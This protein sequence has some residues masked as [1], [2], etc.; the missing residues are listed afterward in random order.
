MHTSRLPNLES[1]TQ[2]AGLL[3]VVMNR[4]TPF[5]LHHYIFHERT[6]SN[7]GPPQSVYEYLPLLLRQ[8][9]SNTTLHKIV[10]A[11]GLAALANSV[12]SMP[13]KCEAYR[14][15]G[16][17]V[18]QLQVDLHDSVKMKSDS[19]LASIMMMSTFEVRT[20]WPS[21]V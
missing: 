15:Y 19:T 3:P 8:E 20:I 11:T 9:T 12:A 13:W 21:L 14:M 7:N 16:L 4:A 1:G 5:F 17:A 10:T 6:S 18:R 2:L